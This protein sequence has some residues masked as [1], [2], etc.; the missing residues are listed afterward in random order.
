MLFILLELK[1]MLKMCFA[2][3]FSHAKA[4]W[5]ARIFFTLLFW[6]LALFT[7]FLNALQG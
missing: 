7:D 3:I 5:L 4:A 6:L 2:I 1:P